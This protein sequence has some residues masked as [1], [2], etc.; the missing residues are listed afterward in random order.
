MSD[1]SY[2]KH[3]AVRLITINRADKMNSLTFEANDDL[4]AAWHEFDNDESA[5]AAVI[6]G[7]GDKA[8]CA[9]ADLKTY[10]MDFARAPAQ[11][12][13][14]KYTNGPGIGGITRNLDID[15]PI[16]AAVNG[17]AISGALNC[18]SPAI[19]AF[20]HPTLSLPC[21][22]PNGAF[23]PAMAGSFVYPKL[24][25]WATPWRSS[26]RANVSMPNTRTALV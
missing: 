3:G 11:E 21:K 15:K 10:T 23:M 16:V 18:R 8:F 26:S 7:A 22:T 17:F 9:G 4:V 6:T 1:I 13:R 20:A 14:K 5:R 19:C 2:E 24:S 12:F 25:V